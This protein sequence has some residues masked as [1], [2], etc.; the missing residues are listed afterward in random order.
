MGRRHGA[1]RTNDEGEPRRVRAAQYVR[2][3]TDHQRYSTENQADAIRAY[4]DAR[5]I[6]IVQTYADH[7]KSGLSIAGRDSLQ[8]LLDDVRTGN[9]DFTMI[10]VYDISRW[11]RFQDAD[12]SASYEFACR[13]AGITIEY[14]AEQFENDGS[15]ASE[16]IKSVKRVMSGEY[17]R[18]L[19]T[20]VFAGQCRL[21]ELGFRQGGTA[22]F[23][24]RR[25]LIDGTGSVKGNLARGEHKSIQTDRVILTLGPHEEVE[26]VRWIYRSFVE[27]GRSEVDIAK[28]LN[29]RQIP[30]ETGSPWS[31]GTVH[32][33]LINPK[34]TGD[35]VWN[36]R[37]SKLKK[38]SQSNAPELWVRRD[39][40]FD[41][42]VDRA[43]FDAVQAIVIA[44]SQRLS[45]D[46]MLDALRRLLT[47]E[48][49]L[50]GL[51]IDEAEG[52]PSSSV[53]QSRFKGLLRAYALIGYTPE[54]D[55]SYVEINR[56]LRAMHPDIVEKTI[57]GIEA[58]GG[59][60]ARSTETGVL[61]VNREFTA[62]I[63]L[64]R[65]HETGAGSR[66]WTI[67]LDDAHRPDLTIA[68]RLDTGNSSILDF[69][70]LPRRAASLFSMRLSETNGVFLDAFRFDTL[71]ALF[72]M[73][74]RVDVLEVAA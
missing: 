30:S 47:T 68:V 29:A 12:E 24:L 71:D 55:Y 4:A 33:V 14:C 10:L 52:L 26:T 43:L 16:I 20:K 66:R 56:T 45:K 27:G 17:S 69:Y 19:S 13:R 31:R 3:S 34:Y 59:A 23:G 53:Y 64:A 40:A 67:C 74:G 42:C 48:G 25:R 63:I 60:V 41:A 7:G 62:S 49:K 51:I 39:S 44:R 73:T 11:G 70:L 36:R 37:S 21:I 2:M 72:E 28:E 18:D 58:A 35:N 57:A 9:V 65:C 38:I 50:S 46:E 61:T 54:R 32:Q 8:R 15:A 5:G 22:G 1:M 6:D